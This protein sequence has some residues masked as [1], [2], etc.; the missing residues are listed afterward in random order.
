VGHWP[1]VIVAFSFI[2]FNIKGRIFTVKEGTNTKSQKP[3]AKN[4]NAHGSWN[5][6]QD[7]HIRFVGNVQPGVLSL[8]GCYIA[9]ASVQSGVSIQDHRYLS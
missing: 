1:R 8:C 4:Q 6:N 3:K 9:D 7:L 2:V 5:Q